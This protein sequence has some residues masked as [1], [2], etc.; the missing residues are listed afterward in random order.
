MSVS[1]AVVA[2]AAGL[3][4]TQ[5]VDLDV[6]FASL[7]DVRFHEWLVVIALIASSYW[8]AASQAPLQAVLAL[9]VSGYCVA[10][11]YLLFGAPDLGMTQF[12]IETL[13]VILVALIFVHLPEVA[14]DTR[15]RVVRTTAIV[16]SALTG[17]VMAGLTL[18]I[19]S[20]EL[21]PRYFEALR[22]RKLRDRPR[23]QHRQRH[24]RRLSGL[25]YVGRNHRSDGRG[26]RR[27]LSAAA[28]RPANGDRLAGTR[29][30]KRP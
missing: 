2:L 5:R 16:I 15:S 10:L 6:D 30:S 20:V 27:L 4:F 11:I 22:R 8:A 19:L 25:R 21:A 28:R 3:A 9:G 13:T 14:Q 26:P 7:A 1:V 17:I 23:P 18:A 12:S 29:S 24:P